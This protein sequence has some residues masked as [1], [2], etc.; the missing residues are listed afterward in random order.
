MDDRSQTSGMTGMETF[1]DRLG[2]LYKG[3][4]ENSPDEDSEETSVMSLLLTELISLN[5]SRAERQKD[6][7]ALVRRCKLDT[8]I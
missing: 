3:S 1:E 5:K 7:K 4:S 6:Q 8:N 2:A